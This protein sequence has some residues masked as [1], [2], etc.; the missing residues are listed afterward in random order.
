MS[1]A[2]EDGTELSSEV[3]VVDVV[4]EGPGADEIG[5]DV[6]PL[7][8]LPPPQLSRRHVKQMR[9]K[10]RADLLINPSDHRETNMHP[11]L[12]NLRPS[13]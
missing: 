3:I 7:L 5:V 4:R 6:V 11:P 9:S 13:D 8:P 10:L 2:S 1:P 12:V